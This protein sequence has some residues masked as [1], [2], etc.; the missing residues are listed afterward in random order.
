MTASAATLA[1]Q[2]AVFAESAYAAPL[3]VEIGSDVRGRVLDILGICAAAS[4]LD[5]SESARRYVREQGGRPQATAVGMTEPITASQAAFVNGVLAHSLDFDDTHLPSVLHPSACVVPAALAAAEHA[6]RTGA[7]AISAIAI[8]LEVTTRLGMAGYDPD[9]KNSV[10]FRHGQHATSIC[11]T[12]GAATAAAL[13]YGLDRAGLTSVLG[14][15]A[16][17]AAGIIEANR[18]GGTVKRLHCGLAAR[19]GIDAAQLVALGFTGPPTVLE[20]R[21]GFFQ[22]WLH[23]DFRAAEVTDGLGTRWESRNIFFKPYPANHFTHTTVDAGRRLRESGVAPEDLDWV[24]IGVPEQDLPTVGQPIEVKRNPQTGYMAQ[25]SAPYALVVGLLGGCG[26]GANLADYTDRLACDPERRRLMARMEV[27][28]DPECTEIFPHQFPVIVRAR[29]RTGK[30]VQVK[31][32]SNRGGPQ[33]PLS[34]ADLTLKFTDNVRGV[35]A[36]ADI[37]LLRSRIDRL[38]EL[39]DVG[40][41]LAPLRLAGST[42]TPDPVQAISTRF[43]ETP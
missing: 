23:G 31:V 32:L 36:P 39:T 3:P 4:P 17:M 42:P 12:M 26:L 37:D 22:A 10:F 19:S 9:T 30:T 18:S 11:G 2:L 5:T 15:A 20:G 25:F 27:V 24:Q 21:F 7:Q 8:G 16:S 13:L 40:L 33:S 43:A 38:D 29:L 41:L 35:L 14:V 1:Q 34:F 28:A 6:G